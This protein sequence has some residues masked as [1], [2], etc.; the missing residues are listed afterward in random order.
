V[1]VPPADAAVLGWLRYARQRAGDDADLLRRFIARGQNLCSAGPSDPAAAVELDEWRRLARRGVDLIGR[2]FDPANDTR[3]W[4]PRQDRRRAALGARLYADR[5]FTLP[6]ASRT[7]LPSWAA[8]TRDLAA[9][10]RQRY[11]RAADEQTRFAAE[12][13]RLRLEALWATP[14]GPAAPDPR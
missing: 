2:A 14:T 7:R 9:W 11:D 1:A 3:A 12:R 8:W 5:A 6:G 10:Q 13:A 4:G